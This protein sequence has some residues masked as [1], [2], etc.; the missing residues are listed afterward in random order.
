MLDETVVLSYSDDGVVA[1]SNKS[2]KKRA[3]ETLSAQYRNEAV[4]LDPSLGDH[5]IRLSITEPKATKDFYG[6][7][8]VSVN[9]RHERSTTQPNG[10]QNFPVVFKIEA[11]MPVG[12]SASNIEGDIGFLRAFV[13]HDV[14]KRLVKSLET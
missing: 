2:F 4:I 7:R 8:R 13:A 9:L 3:H 1:A 5:S 6:T 14:F 11:S 12:V 10:T